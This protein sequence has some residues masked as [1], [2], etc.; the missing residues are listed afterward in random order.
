MDLYVVQST[1]RGESSIREIC[2]MINIIYYIN[3]VL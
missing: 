1:C 2:S 3:I